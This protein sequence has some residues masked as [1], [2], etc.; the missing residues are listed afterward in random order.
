[1]ALDK[2]P[3]VAGHTL[4]TLLLNKLGA[5]KPAA[6]AK[7]NTAPYTRVVPTSTPTKFA[8]VKRTSLNVFVVL[9]PTT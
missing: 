4:L 6:F 8:I 5:T 2:F 1:M 3:V 9:K 7:R